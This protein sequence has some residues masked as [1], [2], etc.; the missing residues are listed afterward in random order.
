MNPVPSVGGNVCCTGNAIQGRSY[1]Q[2]QVELREDVLVY[3]SEP[4]TEGIEVTGFIESTLY[5]SSTGA[6]TDITLKLIDV[7]PDGSVGIGTLFF[8][9][10]EAGISV[11]TD[12]TKRMASQG[13]AIVKVSHDTTVNIKQR[14]GIVTGKH[15]LIVKLGKVCA[16]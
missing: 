5:V 9:C 13:M 2:S 10:K 16:G 11:Q 15:N 14:L 3:T 4:L 1:D 12:N 6:D 7:H 8:K